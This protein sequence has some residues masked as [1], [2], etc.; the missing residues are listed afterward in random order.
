LI[1]SKILY[2]RKTKFLRGNCY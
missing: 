1:K 2:L